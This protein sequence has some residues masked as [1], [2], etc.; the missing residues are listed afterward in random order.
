MPNT[1]LPIHQ[2]AKLILCESQAGSS[3]LVYLCKSF[4]TRQ[5]CQQYD[6]TAFQLTAIF[7]DMIRELQL[8]THKRRYLVARNPGVLSLRHN[9]IWSCYTFKRTVNI[10]RTVNMKKSPF[11]CRALP[12][13]TQTHRF[14]PHSSAISI[15]RLNLHIL[16]LH[17]VNE[18]Q[19]GKMFGFSFPL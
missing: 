2:N 12:K 16:E 18:G 9:N 4:L 6:H 19:K 1:P 7:S 15:M 11:T 14:C 13:K 8:Y 3:G 5:E 10:K 17:I